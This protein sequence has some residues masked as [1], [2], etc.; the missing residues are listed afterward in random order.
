MKDSELSSEIVK[1]GDDGKVIDAGDRNKDGKLD[2]ASERALQDMMGGKLEGG[3][4]VKLLERSV[5]APQWYVEG[6]IEMSEER[7]KEFKE[8]QTQHKALELEKEKYRKTLDT[9]LKKLKSEAASIIDVF[10]E[11]IGA[12]ADLRIGH[13]SAAYELELLAERC[14]V[15]VH[16]EESAIAAIESTLAAL[17]ELQ[18]VH[19]KL[20]ELWHVHDAAATEDERAANALAAEEKALDR[21]LRKELNDQAPIVADPLLSILKQVGASTAAQ[22]AGSIPM[23]SM[24]PDA[25]PNN[26]DTGIWQWCA[27]PASKFNLQLRASLPALRSALMHPQVYCRSFC[28]AKGLESMAARARHR[29]VQCAARCRVP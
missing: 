23:P 29:E 7:A 26:I 10:D 4:D 1:A 5:D 2:E 17:P 12:L 21:K 28:A 8:W 19:V 13:N 25:P 11:S 24:N 18:S 3:R 27:V 20:V 9:E 22:P 15:L 14:A 16:A 6:M